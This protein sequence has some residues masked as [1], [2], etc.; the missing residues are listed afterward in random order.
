IEAALAASD[1]L[2]VVI[3]PQWLQPRV[4][5]PDDFVRKEIEI[6]LTRQLP[7]I[8]LLYRQATMPSPEDLPSSIAALASYQARTLRDNPDFDPDLDRLISAL[9]KLTRTETT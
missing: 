9:Q 2:L 1:V 7:I 3:G 8:P 4:H 6:A 5:D